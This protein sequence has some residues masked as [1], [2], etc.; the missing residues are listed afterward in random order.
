MV[1]LYGAKVP[2][3]G[4]Y[5]EPGLKL[6]LLL[7]GSL[8]GQKS[9]W[10]WSHYCRIGLRENKGQVPNVLSFSW[11]F[12]YLELICYVSINWL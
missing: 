8:G 1:I 7:E 12:Y 2:N 4:W 11:I 6:L 9:R 10:Q 5:M 3:R